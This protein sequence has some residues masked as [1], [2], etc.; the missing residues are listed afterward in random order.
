MTTSAATVRTDYTAAITACEAVV[1]AV[2]DSNGLLHTETLAG[3]LSA[4]E[5][6]ALAKAANNAAEALA[7]LKDEELQAQLVGGAY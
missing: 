6:D 4:F 1:A 3:G 2:H 7:I 5:R